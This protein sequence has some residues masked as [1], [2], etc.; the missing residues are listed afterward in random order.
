MKTVLY[1]FSGTGNSLWVASDMAQKLGCELVPMVKA[2]A[3]QL[4]ESFP[5]VGLVFPTYMYRPPHIVVEFLKKLP[6]TQ[7]LFVVTTNGGDAGG[8]L[9]TTKK[10]LRRRGLVMNAGFTVRMPDNYIPFGGAIPE[11]EQ[12]ELFEKARIKV[13]QIVDMVEAGREHCDPGTTFYKQW[14]HPGIF[15]AM[16][17]AMI[18]SSDRAFWTNDNCVGCGS[19]AK[20]CPVGNIVL[21]EERPTWGGN[22]QQCYGCLQ[23]CKKEAIEHKKVSIGLKRYHHPD[24]R[25]RQI[26]QQH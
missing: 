22:C 15:Y 24:I 1:Y 25:R 16:G 9:G 10:H 17:Y 14:I 20:V 7:Y 23:W 5:R 21:K 2:M 19:C 11:G 12:R 6:Q 26:I 4:D 18:R 13:P 8:V 3:G